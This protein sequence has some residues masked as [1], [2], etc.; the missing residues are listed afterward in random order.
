MNRNFLVSPPD[1]DEEAAIL[2][3]SRSEG[4]GGLEGVPQLAERVIW[5][6]AEKRPMVGEHTTIKTEPTRVVIADSRDLAYEYGKVTT[7]FD[8]KS[9]EHVKLEA[10]LLRVWQKQDGNWK[11][12]AAFAR[13]YDGK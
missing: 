11:E 6:G 13:P 3:R 1:A 10:G 9:A 2:C 8:L 5:T 4:R 7:E 12:A